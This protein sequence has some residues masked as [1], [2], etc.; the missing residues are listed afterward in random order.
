VDLKRLLVLTDDT[1][2]IYTID[3]GLYPYALETLRDLR[4]VSVVLCGTSAYLPKLI[5]RQL[6]TGRPP[7]HDRGIFFEWVK[8]PQDLGPLDAAHRPAR[9]GFRRR[10][11]RPKLVLRTRTRLDG[12]WRGEG[13]PSAM[14]A[15]GQ[16]TAPAGPDSPFAPETFFGLEQIVFREL[17]RKLFQRNK[18]LFNS[19]R[20]S[21]NAVK[22]C[23]TPT[24]VTGRT[25]SFLSPS[26]SFEPKCARWSPG[27]RLRA[28]T[29]FTLS[30]LFCTWPLWA[31]RLCR[32]QTVA[33]TSTLPPCTP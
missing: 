16:L 2:H 32:T 7:A 19:L 29:S 21:R 9:R 31:R 26:R 5:E 20:G 23:K 33:G 8:V 14:S 13:R 27:A 17:Y 30:A 12:G 1:E 18:R 28:P 11:P 3:G 4:R 10:A 6:G 25:P 24:A 22:P 15:S